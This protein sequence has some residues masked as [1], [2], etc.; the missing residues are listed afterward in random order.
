MA[1][2]ETKVIETE[3]NIATEQVE[4]ENN[5]VVESNNDWRWKLVE[6]VTYNGEE[7]SELR[8]NFTK[9]TGKD[10]LEVEGELMRLGKLS[11]YSQISNVEYLMRCA[12]RACEKP[13]GMD[14]F[15]LVSIS[16]FN[17]LRT[18]TQLFLLRTPS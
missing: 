11:M 18:K 7:I 17:T 16:D 12:I 13:I 2:K 5:A 6:P 8:F 14:I 1:T 9:L 15:S 10:A 3:N 4:N